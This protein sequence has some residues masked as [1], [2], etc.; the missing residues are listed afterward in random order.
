ML[1]ILKN[2]ENKNEREKENTISCGHDIDTKIEKLRATLIDAK[3]D[4]ISFT[5]KKIINLSQKLDLLIN[6]A[7]EKDK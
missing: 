5:N 3:K 7:L 2:H 1:I 4:N 6:K